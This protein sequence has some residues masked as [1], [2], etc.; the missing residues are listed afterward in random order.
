MTRSRYDDCDIGL[1]ATWSDPKGPTGVRTRY[2]AMGVAL[3]KTGRPIVYSICCPY[4]PQFVPTKGGW[5]GSANASEGG[6]NSIRIGLTRFGAQAATC[7]E[8]TS[9]L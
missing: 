9:A 4:D 6:G 1:P 7:P 8:R 5:V 3:N 2:A